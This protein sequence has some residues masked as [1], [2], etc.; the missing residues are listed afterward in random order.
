MSHSAQRRFLRFTCTLALAL[1]PRFAAAQTPSA[2]TPFEKIGGRLKV[3]Q[4]AE[5]VDNS[6]LTVRGKVL[7]ISPSTLVLTGGTGTRTF[8]GADVT[9]IRRTGPIWDGAV[10]GGIIGAVPWLRS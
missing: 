10:K 9:V 5:V 1:A 8:T 6:G 7:E 4:V 2:D 3:G